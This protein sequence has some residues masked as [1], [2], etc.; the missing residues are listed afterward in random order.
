[1]SYE[2]DLTFEYLAPTKVIFGQGAI[3][4]LPMEVSAAGQKA[5]L[6]T[7]A[8]I[9]ETGLVDMI[10]EKLG[11]QLCGVFADVPQDSG[12]DVVDNGAERA[13]AAGADVIVS[14]GGG[15]VVDTAKGMCIVMTEGGSLRDFQGMQMLTRPQT[16]HIVI[17][18]T[19]G[20]GS[21]VTAGAVVLDRE[22]G[23]KIIIFEHHNLPRTAILDP[24]MTEKLPPHLTASTGMD[25]MTHA[26]EAYVAIQRNP[27]SDASALHAIRLIADYLPVAVENGSDLVAR[28]QMQVAALL[29]GWAFS[30]AMVGLVHAMAHSLGAICG[31]PHGLANAL[32][33]PHVMQ[34]NLDEIPGLTADIARAMGLDARGMNEAELGSEAVAAMKRLIR[35]IGLP[36]NLR[37]LNIE[38]EH[39]E[40]AA[41]LSLSD[42]SI[43]YNPKMIMEAEEVLNVYREAY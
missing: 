28:G 3:S 36:Q 43:I 19:A 1:M 33:L 24:R 32:L 8:G 12:M 37:D 14:L 5:F 38:Q 15:S 39:L 4:E 13:L 20:T 10:K 29:A 6:V 7:D 27:I 42:G 31:T 41:E 18:T 40:Q 34:F 2:A 23:Q 16:P 25:A 9:S 17:P 26:V 21:E 35:E 30:N 22:Q 11:S